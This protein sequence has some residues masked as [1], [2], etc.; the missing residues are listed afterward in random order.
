MDVI[1]DNNKANKNRSKHGI[2]F[3]DASTV[4][5]DPFAFSREDADVAG[6]QRFVA[7]GMDILGRIL[8]VVYTYRHDDIRLISARLAARKER[9]CYERNLF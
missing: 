8:T 9:D 5:N 4:F 2:E 6:E 7:I 1:W 3:A